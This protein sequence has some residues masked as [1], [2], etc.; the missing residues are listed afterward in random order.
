MD[1]LK[2]DIENCLTIS[3]ATLKLDNRGLVLVQGENV[4][5]SSADSNGA[6]KSSIPDALCW[7]LYGVTARGIR[8]DDVV[9][10]VAKK[11]CRVSV[12][13]SDGGDEYQITRYRKHKDG[14]NSVAVTRTGAA[15]PLTKGTDKLTQTVIDQIVG[16]SHEVFAAAIYA[17]QEAMPNLPAMTDKQLKVLIEESA[18]IELLQSAYEIALARLG[19]SKRHLEVL[20]SAKSGAESMQSMQRVNLDDMTVSVE[21]WGKKQKE[22]VGAKNGRA[23]VAI[24]RANA[25]GAEIDTKQEALLRKNIDDYERRISEQKGERDEEIALRGKAENVSRY[26]STIKSNL[27]A[28][29]GVI[30]QLKADAENLERKIGRPCGECGKAY[31]SGDMDEARK[32]ISAKIDKEMTRLGSMKEDLTEATESA[33]LASSELSKHIE[34]MTNVS[35]VVASL[36]A[37]E[38]GISAIKQ[39]RNDFAQLKEDAKRYVAEAKQIASEANP[40][41]K[42]RE[43]LIAELESTS[44]NIERMLGEI[45]TAGRRCALLADVADV[46]GQSGVRAHILDTV[47]PFLNEKTA[48]YL[49]QLSD[50]NISAIWCTLALTAKSEYREKFNIA[51]T[52]DKG[53]K[54]FAGLSGGEKRKV[55]I[56]T[57]M[58]L[59]DLVASRATKPI[60]L[61]I[62]DEVDDA[63]D[64][65]G[66]ER[67]MGILD[68]KA[69]D[70]GTVLVISHN[71]LSDWIREVVTVKKEN[72]ASTVSGVLCD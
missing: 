4:D 71:S 65:A 64:G 47:T 20:E 59:Q 18:G 45:D 48:E 11:G 7:A 6:G 33:Q 24:E 8:G 16:C 27:T 42:M 23:R 55:R 39:K 40:Y 72:G 41:I 52:N 10:N 63:L 26:E 61:F 37:C 34:S 66:L 70:K 28:L 19:E 22:M 29:V 50:G 57:A 35:E 69:R 5:D 31:E 9:N 51:V 32:I 62:A 25:V 30:K 14:K 53:A 43:T 49:G 1:I 36:R 56:A 2:V 12:H 38:Q 67:L 3:K 54:S 15:E 44:K 46:F 21:E 58:A 17:G 13:L 68:Q 60:G